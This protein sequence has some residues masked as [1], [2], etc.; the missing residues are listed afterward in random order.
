MG[1][2]MEKG[3]SSATPCNEKDERPAPDYETCNVV[4]YGGS[5]SESD[6]EI[7]YVRTEQHQCQAVLRSGTYIP[8][9][10]PPQNDET[11]RAKTKAKGKEI[12]TPGESN[13]P[14]YVVHDYKF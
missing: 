5:S 9:R 11:E 12:L 4:V 3:E 14:K 7:V 13:S 10:Q 2:K 1:L 6:E 8:E